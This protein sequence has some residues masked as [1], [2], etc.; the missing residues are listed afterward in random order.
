MGGDRCPAPR[1]LGESGHLE[2][3]EHGHRD[4]SGDRGRRHDQDM[5]A[6][7][8]TH[9]RRER[10]PLLDPEPVLLV[11]HDKAKVEELHSVLEQCVSSDDDAAVSD[12]D[13]QE[14]LATTARRQRSG[15]ERHPG[16]DVRATEEPA[17]GERAQHRRDRPVVL[18]GED[19]GG[20]EQDGL[21]AVI[22]HREHGAQGDDR[23]AR[24]DLALQEPVHRVRARHVLGDRSAHLELSGGELEGQPRLE[25]LEEP[26]R[27]RNTRSGRQRRRRGS[28]LGKN[29]LQHECLIPAQPL[30]CAVDIGPRLRAMDGQQR[31]SQA[32]QAESDPGGVGDGVLEVVGHLVK[33]DRHRA[34]DLPGGHLSRRRIDRDQGAR[35]GEHGVH[36][37]SARLRG[38][39]LGERI[40]EVS[41][42]GPSHIVGTVR[43]QHVV[44]VCQ[45]APTVERAN[46]SREQSEPTFAKILGTPGLL[47]VC[48][49]QGALAV[50]DDDLEAV[51]PATALAIDVGLDVDLLH[52]RHHGD[53]LVDLERGEVGELTTLGIAPRIVAQQILDR[54]EPEARGKCGGR[55]GTEHRG[56]RVGQPKLGHGLTPPRGS[57]ATTADHRR[58]P[59]SRHPG[60]L[61]EPAARSSSRQRHRH[62]RPSRA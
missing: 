5:G 49:G 6:L 17:F 3:P 41:E 19:L 40:A 21:A 51:S 53:V 1:K 52:A 23:L 28:T 44:R 54:A 33:D 61:D 22:D 55:A 29:G 46:L 59:R 58:A 32:G 31:A 62:Q 25:V 12:A 50:R 42:L 9:L 20:C 35:E 47:E 26:A 30:T 60:G 27:P 16:P 24:A 39:A 18:L 8:I 2:I 10:R 48:E 7:V 34:R 37:R 14:H 13:V 43:E 45:L 11:D 15:D 57:A 4:S 38:T 36:I 56:E